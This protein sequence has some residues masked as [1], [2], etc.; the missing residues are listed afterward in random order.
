MPPDPADP[1]HDVDWRDLLGLEDQ[2]SE[3]EW[4]VM[5]SA[6]GFARDKLALILGRAMTKLPAFG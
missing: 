6:R 4:P 1:P 3:D 5:T 2:L